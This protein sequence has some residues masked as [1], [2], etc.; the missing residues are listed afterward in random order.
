VPAARNRVGGYGVTPRVVTFER[1]DHDAE[2]AALVS[3]LAAMETAAACL[4]ERL[5]DLERSD[6][7]RRGRR[8][9]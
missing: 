5:A 3:L 7:R 9:R 4:R 6:R 1:K 2:I 8:A